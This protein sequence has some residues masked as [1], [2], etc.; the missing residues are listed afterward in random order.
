MEHVG[1]R[2]FGIRVR[3]SIILSK[4]AVTSRR[5]ADLRGGGLITVRSHRPLH[6]VPSPSVTPVVHTYV[7]NV[8][9]SMMP[10][11]GITVTVTS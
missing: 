2:R 6:S 3:T 9:S 4:R 5:V 7:T 10:H 11:Q 8:S 1:C